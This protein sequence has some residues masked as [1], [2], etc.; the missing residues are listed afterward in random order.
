MHWM[1][2]QFHIMHECYASDY[3][4]SETA[5]AYSNLGK[6]FRKRRS[7]Q[8]IALRES[9]PAVF[10]QK[11][12]PLIDW[13]DTAVHQESFSYLT[14]RGVR[15][16]MEEVRKNPHVLL[17]RDFFRPELF[18]R[19]VHD[20]PSLE[21]Y[22]KQL[23]QLASKR[24]GKE[25]NPKFVRVEEIDFRDF[26]SGKPLRP[27]AEVAPEAFPEYRTLRHQYEKTELQEQITRI[28][29]QYQPLMKRL[30]PALSNT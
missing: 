3:Y 15:K 18:A 14:L 6:E 25:Q 10:F 27:P 21:R 19:I 17:H 7:L 26:L 1:A 9:D 8:R 22:L 12:K 5:L 2:F 4:W 29:K 30:S 28:R 20:K 24:P 16:T 11:V 23:L 13:F